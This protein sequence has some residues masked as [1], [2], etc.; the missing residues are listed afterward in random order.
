MDPAGF[1]LMR[2]SGVCGVRGPERHEALGEGADDVGDI[3]GADVGDAD[4]G[5]GSSRNA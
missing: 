3:A 2:R 4:Q 5:V 1:R